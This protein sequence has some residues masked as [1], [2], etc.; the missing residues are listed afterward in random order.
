VP[1]CRWTRG[2]ERVA[3][4]S[5]QEHY[6]TDAIHHEIKFDVA[7]ARLYAALLDAHEFAAFTGAPA[8]ID[9]TPGGAFSL[10]GGQILGRNVELVADQ[11]VVQA[12]R[13]AAWLPGV[14]SLVRF[15][16]VANGDGTTLVFDHDAYPDGGH[17]DLDA[18]WHTMYW[19]PLRRHVAAT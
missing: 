16:L 13:V 11:R 15:E 1:L 9:S 19:E 2:I 12:W 17:D 8:E 3:G 10:F 18:G 5:H 6:V 14:Y 7:P 4:L